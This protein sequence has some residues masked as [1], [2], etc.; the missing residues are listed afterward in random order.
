MR[1]IVL[2]SCVKTKLKHAAPAKELYTSQLFKFSLAYARSL[3]PDA[4]YVL[5][6][7]YGVVEL[8]QRIEP[9]EMTLNNMSV[10]ASKEWAK[11]VV[12][13]L[14]ELIDLEKD[15]IVFIAGDKYRKFLIPHIRNYEI[16]LKGLSFG[17]QLQYM[18]AHTK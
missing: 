7:K 10:S 9:Y 15:N 4:I 6:A 18:K 17:R 11:N 3:N 16:P 8:D 2:I 13:R 14:E 1:K 12:S 5:S